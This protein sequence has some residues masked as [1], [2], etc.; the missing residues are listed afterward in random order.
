MTK[1]PL[2]ALSAL[3]ALSEL[4]ASAAASRLYDE[5]ITELQHALQ[6][7]ELATAAGE[8]DALLAAALLPDVGHL[9]RAVRAGLGAGLAD[10]Y[11]L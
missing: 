6:C 2:D 11:G 9:L 10:D 4:Y 7:A 5:A 1:L 8:S 3:D